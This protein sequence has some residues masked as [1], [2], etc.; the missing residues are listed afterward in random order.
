M[1][2][3]VLS[4]YGPGSVKFQNASCINKVWGSLLQLVLKKALGGAGVDKNADK[5]GEGMPLKISMKPKPKPELGTPEDVVNECKAL[6]EMADV[7]VELDD[8][9]IDT[10]EGRRYEIIQGAWEPLKESSGCGG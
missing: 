8:R 7:V 3:S 10:D 6:K 1:V 9:E 5:E 4:N 2:T